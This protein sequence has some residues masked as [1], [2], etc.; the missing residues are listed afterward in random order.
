MRAG[1]LSSSE[2]IKTLN[3]EFINTWVLLRELPGLIGGAKGESVSRIAKK[4]KAHYT[5]SVDILAL[6]AEGEVLMH[7][8]EKA[9]PYKESLHAYL[10]LLRRSVEAFEG[11]VLSKFEVSPIRLGRKVKSVLQTFR[12]SGSK[13]LD[14]TV[15]DID[16]T[17]FESGGILS[18]EIEVGE[19]KATGLFKLFDG[20]AEIRTEVFDTHVLPCETGYIFHRFNR[21]VPFKLAVAGWDSERGSTNAFH[22]HIYVLPASEELD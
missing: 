13:D 12:T 17:P 1:P 5:D 18:I 4:L 14:Y 10:T 7:Q 2:V 11:N 9:L 21:G 19:G 3:E 6:T 22:A 16:A 15:V 8:P 20:E